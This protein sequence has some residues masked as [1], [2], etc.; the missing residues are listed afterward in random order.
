MQLPVI[1]YAAV[2]TYLAQYNIALR[3][4]LSYAVTFSG[5]LADVDR[6]FGVECVKF[7]LSAPAPVL[8]G[9]LIPIEL[10]EAGIVNISF[11]GGG[12]WAASS[13]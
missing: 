4:K 8:F 12:Y 1:D 10:R 3:N 7:P 6:A 13:F 9:E 5:K 11:S 2:R